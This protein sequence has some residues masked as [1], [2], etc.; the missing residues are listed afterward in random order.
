M[1]LGAAAIALVATACF[2]TTPVEQWV[3]D[4]NRDGAISQAEIDAE[5]ARLIQKGVEAINA[6]RRNVQLNPTLT[7]IRRH[8]SD[9]GAYPHTNGYAAKNPRSTAS[10]AYQFLNSTWQNVSR[11]AGYPGYATARQA[12]WHVQD[13]VAMWVIKNHGKSAWRGTGC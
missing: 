9:R 3:P 7:C 1:M 13:A 11:A 4:L 6:H 2:P 10:G 8:E 12:P 5:K